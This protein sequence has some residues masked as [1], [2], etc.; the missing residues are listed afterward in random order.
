MKNVGIICEYNPFHNG[1][2]AQLS[3]ARERGTVVCLM[4][5]NYVQRGEPALI[6][7]LVRA[8]AAVKSGASL[9]LEL[10]VTYALRSAEGFADGGVEIFDRLGCVDTLCFGSESGDTTALRAT[11]SLLLDATFS[12]CLKDAL[13]TGVS[14]PTARQHA[15]EKLGGDGALIANPN[16]ILGVEYC[17]A[18]QKRSSRIEPLAVHR[19]GSYHDSLLPEAPSASVLRQRGDWHGFMPEDVERLQQSAQR[20]TIPAGERAMLARLRAMTEPEF[21]ALPFGSEGLWRKLMHACREESTLA[22]IVATVKSKRYTHTRVM[23]MVLCAFLG[24]RAENLCSPAP[25]VRVLAMDER[26]GKLLR[27]MRERGSVLHYGER[28]PQCEFAEIERRVEALYGLFAESGAEAPNR[29]GNVR[30]C[31]S[32]D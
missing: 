24:L 16:D 20:H 6:D 15:L 28:A 18:L 11:A 10:P 12:D 1:H 13:N 31:P 29:R 14:F 4:S 7:K 8:E 19:T 5:G 22:E 9:V 27:R 23:R 26:G 21:A 30:F 17:K 3:I 32:N 2:A 25:Y